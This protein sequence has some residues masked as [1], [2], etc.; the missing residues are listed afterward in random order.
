M[1]ATSTA[2]AALKLTEPPDRY[3]WACNAPVPQSKFYQVFQR[4]GPHRG[5]SLGSW[6]ICDACLP[7]KTGKGTSFTLDPSS[8]RPRRDPQ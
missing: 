2:A 1:S 7:V 3:C 4:T 6:G 5:A 8:V